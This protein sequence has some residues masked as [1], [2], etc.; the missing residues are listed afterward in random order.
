[1][2]ATTRKTLG[3]NRILGIWGKTFGIPISLTSKEKGISSIQEI[4]S[5]DQVK[6]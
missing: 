4:G 2:K 1:M 3:T 6:S 5:R